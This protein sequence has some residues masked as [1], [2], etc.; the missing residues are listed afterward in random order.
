MATFPEKVKHARSELGLTQAELGE[1][2]GVSL[3]TILDYEKGKKVPR[4]ATLLK[5]ARALKVS[6]RFLTD[7][8]CDDPLEDIARDGYI[9][10]ARK[11]YGAKGGREIDAL[12][13]ESV[14]LF[15]GGDIPQEEKDRFFDALMTAYVKSKEAAKKTYGRKK[16]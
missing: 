14:A 16:E 5:L 15:A 6:S 4:Q 8:S 11:S 7:D 9:T 12:L 2:T 1:A 13:S 10:E 3:R